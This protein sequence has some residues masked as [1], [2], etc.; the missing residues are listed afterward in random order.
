[1]TLLTAVNRRVRHAGV[2]SR[3]I[4]NR[5]MTKFGVVDDEGQLAGDAQAYWSGADDD[6][7]KAN[8]HWRDASVFDGSDLWSTVGQ[9]HLELYRRLSRL[10]APPG[11]VRGVLE[12]GCG[13]GANAVHFAGLGTSFVGVDVSQETLDECGRQL[14][15]ATST[16]SSSGSGPSWA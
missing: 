15:A 12:W 13:G 16:P 8:S 2:R 4:K 10:S 1:M 14:A 7:W 3:D 11:P 6:R 5:L 9:H